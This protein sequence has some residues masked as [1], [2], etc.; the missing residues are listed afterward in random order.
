[1]GVSGV[2]ALFLI[3]LVVA[4]LV[5]GWVIMLAATGLH[6]TYGWPSMSFANA[7]LIAPV[8]AAITAGVTK[9]N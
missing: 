7:L 3:V 8:F 1:M 4:W 2:I 6:Y 9:K 5:W